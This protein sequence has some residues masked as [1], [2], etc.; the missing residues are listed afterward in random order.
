MRRDQAQAAHLVGGFLSPLV[1]GPTPVRRR[2]HPATSSAS[3]AVIMQRPRS[4][5]I[6]LTPTLN[7]RVN[8]QPERQLRNQSFKLSTIATEAAQSLRT[9][10]S[11]N[12]SPAR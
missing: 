2:W 12:V 4:K 6:F 11:L 3:P 1:P 8:P 9:M 5:R 7:L 10:T